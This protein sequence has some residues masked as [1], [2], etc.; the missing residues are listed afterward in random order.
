MDSIKCY[1]F[2]NLKNTKIFVDKKLESDDTIFEYQ[3]SLLADLDYD[4]ISELIV[5]D[6]NFQ[7]NIIIINSITGKKKM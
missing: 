5:I 6:K 1:S 7:N 3:I 4:C 2:Q